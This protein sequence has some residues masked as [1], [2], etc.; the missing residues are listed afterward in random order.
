[1]EAWLSD[2]G[3][4]RLEACLPR[5]PAF[6]NRFKPEGVRALIRQQRRQKSRHRYLWTLIQ[7]AIWHKLFVQADGRPPPLWQDPLE[8]LD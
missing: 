4:N 2:A 7:L 5:H 6:E 1:M 3:L 8:L